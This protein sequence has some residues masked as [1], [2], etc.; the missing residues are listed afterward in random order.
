[1]TSQVRAMAE[2]AAQKAGMTLEEYAFRSMLRV[3]GQPLTAQAEQLFRK[4][5]AR[6]AA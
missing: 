1:M 2:E 4:E 3:Y 6:L 5:A